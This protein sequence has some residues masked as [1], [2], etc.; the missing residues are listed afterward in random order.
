MMTV[1]WEHPQLCPAPRTGQPTRQER[2][3]ACTCPNCGEI[4][5]LHAHDARANTICRR[6]QCRMAGKIGY[7]V[8]TARYGREQSLTY[9]R[10]YQLAHPSKP[11]LTVAVWLD[12]LCLAYERQYL[13]RTASQR[14][15]IDFVIQDAAIE[16]NGYFHKR[17]G[18]ARDLRLSA[19]WP[20]VI[21]FLDADQITDAPDDAH[22]TLCSFLYC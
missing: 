1:D 14:Y 16:V 2:F 7:A 11:E 8:T 17:D 6:C 22:H 15:L 20:G 18:A 12:A 10:N 13:F 4:R 9:V 5:W 3:Y 21:L 19:E